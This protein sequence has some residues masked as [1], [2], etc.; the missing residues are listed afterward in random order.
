MK[1]KRGRLCVVL[2]IEEVHGPVKFVLGS[3]SVLAR[4]SPLIMKYRHLGVIIDLPARLFGSVSEVQI[5]TVEKELL[6]EIAY[7]FQGLPP[8][9]HKGSH[10]RVHL[11]HLVGV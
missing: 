4:G 9:H 3:L 11:G 2:P 8:D 6:I 5:F 7:L 1:P 10:Y